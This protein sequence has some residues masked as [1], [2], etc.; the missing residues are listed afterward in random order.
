MFSTNV[1]ATE[2]NNRLHRLVEELR[3][4]GYRVTAQRLTI[5]RIVLENV[6]KHPSFMQLLGEIRKQVPSISPSTVYNNLQLLEQLGF[7]K[8][9]DVAGETHYDEADPHVNIVCI[10]TGEIID[11]E[12]SDTLTRFIND[13]QKE[14]EELSVYEII[15]HAFCRRGSS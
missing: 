5:A 8:S 2:V 13:L 1:P 14:K 3:K 15:I 11:L 10:D 6:K 9:F 12:P 7:I 4:R